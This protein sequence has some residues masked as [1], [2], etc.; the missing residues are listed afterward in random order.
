MLA[1]SNNFFASFLFHKLL[2][3]LRLDKVIHILLS[4]FAIFKVQSFKGTIDLEY[5]LWF[6][7][8]QSD[9]LSPYN[10]KDPCSNKNQK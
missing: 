1:S 3:H 4:L 10:L 5:N 6:Y 8:N 2:P 9:S 7:I